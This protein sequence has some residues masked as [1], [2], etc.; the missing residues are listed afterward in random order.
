MTYAAPTPS[1]FQGRFPRFGSVDAGPIT[2]V[3]KQAGRMAD[4]GWNEDDRLE[5]VFLF[6][7]HLLTLDG[8]GGGEADTYAQ[9]T[10]GVK[11]MSS[12]SLS[13]VK[14]DTALP[15]QGGIGQAASLTSTTFGQRYLQLARLN[16]GSGARAV[17]G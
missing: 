9:G 1:D 12:G 4:D 3:L 5:A 13:I 2:R 16:G 17:I 7:A 11:S 10:V 6:A 14:Y 8:F 15:G